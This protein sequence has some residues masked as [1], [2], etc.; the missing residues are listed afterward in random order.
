MPRRFIKS[1]HPGDMG[2]RWVDDEY[3]PGAEGGRQATQ[4]SE[5]EIRAMIEESAKRQ[6]ARADRHHRPVEMPEIDVRIPRPQIRR[7]EEQEWRP[8]MLLP[9]D[10]EPPGPSYPELPSSLGIDPSQLSLQAAIAAAQAGTLGRREEEPFSLAG[11]GFRP[12]PP[13]EDRRDDI[14]I[15]LQEPGRDLQYQIYL[16]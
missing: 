4:M 11:S 9:D 8:P 10:Y 14:P 3:Q 6:A 1:Q 13:A 15:E 5:R 2:G 7:E 16:G 12:R